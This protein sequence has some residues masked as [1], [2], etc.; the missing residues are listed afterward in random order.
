MTVETTESPTSKA[1]KSVKSI[2]AKAPRALFV[3]SYPP[4]LCGL[5]KFLDDLTES[6]PGQYNVIAV[7]EQE[8]DIT[9]RSYSNKVVY[10][11]NQTDRDAY[12]K[13]ANM[14]NTGAYD[15]LNLQ[16]DYGLYG[17]LYGE[18]VLHLLSSVR[19]PIITTFHT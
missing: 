19:K 12:F 18:Y 1:I 6:Y 3:G 15:V 8:A 13:V 4:R 17:G 10:H 16:H 11:F 5:A 14:I 2:D 7:N 9:T